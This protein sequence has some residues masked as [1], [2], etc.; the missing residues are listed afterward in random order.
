[1]KLCDNTIGRLH[2]IHCEPWTF[3]GCST[4]PIHN[5]CTEFGWLISLAPLLFYLQ[6]KRLPYQSDEAMWVTELFWRLWK[7]EQTSCPTWNWTMTPRSAVLSPVGIP[8]TPYRLAGEH[9]QYVMTPY[10][11]PEKCELSITPTSSY[12]FTQYPSEFCLQFFK[13]NL[14]KPKDIYTGCPRRNVPDFGRVFLMLNYT[15]ITQNT[16]IQSWTAT[17]IMAREV[18]NFDSCYTLPDC[19]IHIETGWNMWFR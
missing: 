10:S 18:W 17:E 8:R 14:L 6:G 3:C 2:I 12:Y 13:L 7:R 19:Q 4:P 1:M 9:N 5:I 16:Y 11:I 15:D